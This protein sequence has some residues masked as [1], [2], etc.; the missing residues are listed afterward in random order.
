MKTY[1]CDSCLQV[2]RVQGDP[3]ELCRL[4]AQNPTWK[5]R[6]PCVNSGCSGPLKLL[7]EDVLALLSNVL[8]PG[9]IGVVDLTPREMFQAL[10]GFGLPEE[11]GQAPEVVVALLRSTSISDVAVRI[12][13]SGRTII[14]RLDLSNRLSIHLAASPDGAVAFKIT[15]GKHAQQLEHDHSNLSSDPG[16]V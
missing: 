2:I 14:D 13:P 12:S 5:D 15:R 10:C 11:V 8:E 7:T 1:A 6:L 16:E 4:I 3:E 9:L